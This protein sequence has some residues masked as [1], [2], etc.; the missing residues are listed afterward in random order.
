MLKKDYVDRKSLVFIPFGADKGDCPFCTAG[1]LARDFLVE[2]SFCVNEGY[3]CDKC[4]MSFI[5]AVNIPYNSPVG[6]RYFVGVTHAVNDVVVH[7]VC[8]TY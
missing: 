7:S 5:E 3:S 4:R 2:Q 6:S 1:V 8:C